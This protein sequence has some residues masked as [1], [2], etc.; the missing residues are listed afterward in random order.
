MSESQKNHANIGIEWIIFLK[1]GFFM[2]KQIFLTFLVFLFFTNH[3]FASL[4]LRGGYGLQVTE[5]K[6]YSKADLKDF[7]GLNIDAF[8]RFP[9]SPFGLGLRYEDMNFKFKEK[10]SRDKN[11][12][13]HRMSLLFNYRFL[14]SV[15]FVGATGT[16]GFSNKLNVHKDFGE[17]KSK[18]DFT[19]TLAAE[20]GVPIMDFISLAG[21]LG[22]T[23]DQVYKNR[24]NGASV[25]LSGLYF[26][27]ILGLRIDIF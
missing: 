13:L 14:D 22:Y 4:N 17:L 6:K 16:I 10:N 1:K 7:K 3:A 9:E 5:D 27:L 15:F 2:K 8:V 20:A 12:K 23:I 24:N 25:N 18:S 11:S 21:E 26:K 19:Y